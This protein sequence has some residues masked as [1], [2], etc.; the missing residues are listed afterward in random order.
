MSTK[1]TKKARI[2]AG[3]TQCGQSTECSIRTAAR[4]MPRASS[5]TYMCSSPFVGLHKRGVPTFQHARKLCNN[6]K[7]I[8]H[9][10]NMGATV[11]VT[12]RRAQLDQIARNSS[13]CHDRPQLRLHQNQQWH[14]VL[15]A[16]CLS[17]E[18]GV[19]LE[20][21]GFL[22]RVGDVQRHGENIGPEVHFIP[23]A[24]CP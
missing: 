6:M 2:I 12:P 22:P 20:I 13:N 17:V 21:E 9:K 4:P 1:G 14:N 3:T 11:V 10:C 24:S 15:H 18:V 16:G 23:Q 7:H 19:H 5:C 8:K